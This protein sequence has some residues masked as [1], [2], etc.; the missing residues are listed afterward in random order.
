MNII[1]IA[2]LSLTINATFAQER[3][4]NGLVIDQVTKEPLPFVEI[5]LV[6]EIDTINLKTDFDGKFNFHSNDI[7]SYRL[8]TEYVGFK[9]YDTLI[10]V[11]AQYYILIILERNFYPASQLDGDNGE[12]AKEHIK[13][14]IIRLVLP[15]S[16][17]CPVLS[18][19]DT[20]F[21]L[22]YALK[23]TCQGCIRYG[24]ENYSEYNYFMA[25]FLD[26]KYG[27][28]WRKYA[29]KDIIGLYK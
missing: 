15:G 13:A 29:R 18:P 28:R 3:D 7:N 2:I 6:S 27:K 26:K 20:I 19:A 4:I 21:E 14:N 5:K 10:K 9:N 23:Y 8:T 22:N 12:R 11:L 25:K 16:F 17:A 24:N 1:S